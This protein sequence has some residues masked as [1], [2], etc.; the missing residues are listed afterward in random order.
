MPATQPLLSGVR[1]L[2][3]E[4]YGATPFGTQ[5]L[6]ELGAE[7]IKVEQPED[8]GDVSRHVGPHYARG[9]PET[10]QSIFFQGVNFG[11]KSITLDLRQAEGRELFRQLV[12]GAHAVASNMRG[13]VPDKLGITWEHLKNINPAIVCAHLTGYGRGGERATWPGYDYLMQAEAGYFS[14]TGEPDTPPTRMGL[15][16]VDYMT[17]ALMSLG[18]VSGLVGARASGVGCDVDVSLYA[19]ALHN[20]NYVGNWY[21]NTGT[22]TGREPRSAHPSLTPCALYRTADGWIYLMCNKEKFWAKLCEK[23]GRTEWIRDPRFV[24]FPARLA[25]RHVLTGLLDGALS[26]RTTN[27]WMEVF[28]GT[29]PAAPIRAVDDA[30]NAPFAQQDDRIRAI[31]LPDG[32]TLRMLR[33]PLRTSRGLLDVPPGPAHGANTAEI[34]AEIGV[35]SARLA[36]LRARGVV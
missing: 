26:E 15:S 27:A 29:V 9:L 10:A 20:L 8:G 18:L 12:R 30:L 14:L 17:G 16:M 13:D 25:H 6:A 24:D 32:S 31:P 33:S 11:K 23:I 4:Q 3:V 19:V 34:L 36:D 28:A 22:V 2:A 35:D 7:I 5:Y 1:V 21:L